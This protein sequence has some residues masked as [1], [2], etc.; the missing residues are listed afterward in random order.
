[1]SVFVWTPAD[2]VTAAFLAVIAAVLAVAFVIDGIQRVKK[3]LMK[4]GAK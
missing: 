1:M 4:G 2:A 3:W